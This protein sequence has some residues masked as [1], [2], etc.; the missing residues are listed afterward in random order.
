M[1]YNRFPVNNVL[2]TIRYNGNG[3]QN[4]DIDCRVKRSA[5]VSGAGV[6]RDGQECR[7]FRLLASQNQSIYEVDS[8]LKTSYMLQIGRIHR[9]CVARAYQPDGQCDG[10]A[11]R[12]MTCASVRS[13]RRYRGLTTP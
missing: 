8:N 11:R 9:A 7:R 1:F 4:Y 3:Q 2:N 10:Y 12:C 6:L 13:M 5:G